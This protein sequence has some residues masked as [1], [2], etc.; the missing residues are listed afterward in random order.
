MKQHFLEKR[1][2]IF[3]L[4]LLAAGCTKNNPPAEVPD[5]KI[6]NPQA[7]TQTV[8]ADQTQG[9][10]AVA[11]TTTGAWSTSITETTPTALAAADGAPEHPA[12]GTRGGV[13]SWISVSPSSGS[14]A[15]SHSF[16]ITLEQNFSGAQRSAGITILS[17][18]GQ[19]Q[20][21][22]TQK[23]TKQ[24]GDPNPK[25]Y[26]IYI[27][28]HDANLEQTPVYWKN[29]VKRTLPTKTG[30]I[31][32]VT[33]MAVTEANVYVVGTRYAPDGV[34]GGVEAVLWTNG[35]ESILPGTMLFNNANGIKVH[36]NDVYVVGW[37]GSELIGTAKYWKNG[38]S[39]LLFQDELM[40]SFGHDI[41][42]QGND[43]YVAGYGMRLNEYGVAMYWKNGVRTE[44]MDGQ[45]QGGWVKKIVVSG[46]DVHLLIDTDQYDEEEDRLVACHFHWKNGQWNR[47][48]GTDREVDVAYHMT[49]YNGDVY[50]SGEEGTYS[51]PP[52]DYNAKY[53]KNGQEVHMPGGRI[54]TG[55]SIAVADGDVYLLGCHGDSSVPGFTR[56]VYW[57]NGEMVDVADGLPVSMAVVPHKR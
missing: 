55:Q 43:V 31:T 37:E 24:N 52:Y 53:W 18:G 29:G 50:T 12:S 40:K 34:D 26:D 13:P 48:T 57:K 25:Q 7:L 30:W 17:G 45:E 21:T 46:N 49:L 4:L 33:G 2:A 38:V 28:G 19:Q 1:A 15:G 8:H 20:V 32:K 27:A 5:V 44:L 9:A 42:V 39:T 16:T 41:E 47:L 10:A 14:Q 56:V 11:F 35:V 6:D 51:A 36:N 23:A 54:A 3:A 22:V